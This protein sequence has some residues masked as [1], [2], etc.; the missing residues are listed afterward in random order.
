MKKLFI[1]F[2]AVAGFGVSSYAQVKC[3]SNFNS[4]NC[5]ANY[6]Y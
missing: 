1:L 5:H 4:N 3:Y 6:N 2:I